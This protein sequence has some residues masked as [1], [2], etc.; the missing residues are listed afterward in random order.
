MGKNK[1]IALGLSV[2]F[3]AGSMNV[4]KSNA[5]ISNENQMKVVSSDTKSLQKH[6]M[7]A[8]VN[9]T[10]RKVASNS[11]K[12]LGTLKKGTK[13]TVKSISNGWVKFNYKGS[14]GYVQSK[15]LNDVVSSMYTLEKVDIKNGAGN[16][17]K[18]LG[19]LN[20]SAKV[21]VVGQSGNWTK[22]KYN[23]R[24]GYILS[25]NLSKTKPSTI[26]NDTNKPNNS[27]TNSS[28]NKPNDNANKPNNSTT[29]SSTNKPNDNT[30]KPSNNTNSSDNK[31]N[32]NSIPNNLNFYYIADKVS[33]LDED[34]HWYWSDGDRSRIYCEHGVVSISRF[35]TE[36]VDSIGI[37]KFEEDEMEKDYIREMVE[38][39]DKRLM[40]TLSI[41]FGDKAKDVK[42]DM[43][44]NKNMIKTINGIKL[45]FYNVGNNVCLGFL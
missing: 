41:I 28:T 38:I 45:E 10:I 4:V 14:N 39:R 43:L 33:D 31:P 5:M 42:K 8:T 13:I 16:N 7:K 18:T 1:I 15:Y 27:T 30:N 25:K 37:M 12:K 20:K 34:S 44:S 3:I 35:K 26:S 21:S 23:N 36:K 22:V 17:H 2:M 24:Y 29:N 9:V 40:Q 6:T 11:S 19:T 32:N